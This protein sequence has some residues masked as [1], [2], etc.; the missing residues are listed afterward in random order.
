MTVLGNPLRSP[1][2]LSISAGNSEKYPDSHNVFRSVVIHRI[3]RMMGCI[4]TCTIV[5]VLV[6][7][8]RT[9]YAANQPAAGT[10]V[11]GLG[12]DSSRAASTGRTGLI[13]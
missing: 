3:M 7:A 2:P 11:L 1:I 10:V 8:S 4:R 9:E 5:L 6:H 12:L 13:I